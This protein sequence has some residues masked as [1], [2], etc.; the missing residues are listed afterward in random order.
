MAINPDGVSTNDSRHTVY[1]KRMLVSRS[2]QGLAPKWAYFAR[3]VA[4][5]DYLRLTAS[6]E[7]LADDAYCTTPPMR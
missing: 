2:A 5:A 4:D 6:R 3:V 1:V 7:Q